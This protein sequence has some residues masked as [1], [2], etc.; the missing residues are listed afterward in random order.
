MRMP[1]C[2]FPNVL[3]LSNVVYQS[4][5][6]R[7]LGNRKSTVCCRTLGVLSPL[8]LGKPVWLP[9]LCAVRSCG[10]GRCS[11]CPW[12]FSGSSEERLSHSPKCRTVFF[13][14]SVLSAFFVFGQSAASGTCWKE[15][16]PKRNPALCVLQ[17]RNIQMLFTKAESDVLFILT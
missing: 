3:S 12:S 5:I 1:L 16:L 17:T 7:L 8:L 2:S 13:P 6:R 10:S 9:P 14:V 11:W 15:C 4:G